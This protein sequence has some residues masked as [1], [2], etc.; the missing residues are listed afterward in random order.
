VDQAA[1]G[2]KLLVVFSYTDPYPLC[3]Y[4]YPSRADQVKVNYYDTISTELTEKPRTNLRD[5]VLDCSPA[6]GAGAGDRVASAP[7]QRRL[8]GPGR[9]AHGGGCGACGAELRLDPEGGALQL[10]PQRPRSVPQAGEATR[11]A[12]QRPDHRYDCSVF[13]PS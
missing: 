13:P 2:K 12:H 7:H 3:C 11:P 9:S 4:I 5:A 1:K 10:E 8:F 6:D